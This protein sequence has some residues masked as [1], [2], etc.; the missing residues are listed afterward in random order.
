[1][2]DEISEELKKKMPKL[3]FDCWIELIKEE[4]CANSALTLAVPNGYYFN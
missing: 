1:M 2:W 3:E 4:C